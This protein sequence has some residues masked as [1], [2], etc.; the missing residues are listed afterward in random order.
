MTAI[1]L[2]IKFKF[3]TGEMP[4]WCKKQWY[5]MYEY[6]YDGKLKSIYGLWLEEHIGNYKK[7]R[8]EYY[9]YS[10]LDPV[11]RRRTCITDGLLQEYILWLEDLALNLRNHCKAL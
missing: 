8:D 4:T 11:Y 1:D 9:K 6:S 5:S 7:L 3:D 2:R 10:G